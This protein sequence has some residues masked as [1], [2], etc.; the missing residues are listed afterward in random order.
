MFSN[1]KILSLHRERVADIALNDIEDESK[2]PFDVTS[3][4]ASLSVKNL[5]FQYDQFTQPI[6]KNIQLD[7]QSGESVA[8]SAPSG[9]GKTT[10][11]K[12]MSG[13]LKPSSGKIYFNNIDIHQLGLSNYREKIACVLQ[14]DKFFSGSILDNIVS[15]EENYERER[16]IECAKIANIHHEIMNMPMNYETLLCEL[17]NNLSGGQK[18]R[19]FIA[20]ALYK[21]PRILFMDEATSHLDEENE[22][23]INQAISNLN[24]TRVIIAHRKSTLESA[25]RIIY[26]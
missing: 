24:I 18:Q 8:I 6:L 25:D 19:L 1:L 14:D 9:F 13:L 22:K 26:L 3:N 12:L 10:L 11:L 15:F 20:R 4:N 2:K 7:I 16:A 5:C 17:G 21:R 23:A